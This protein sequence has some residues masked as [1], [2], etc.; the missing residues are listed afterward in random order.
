MRL[1][2]L[3]LLVVL[4]LKAVAPIVFSPTIR[5]VVSSSFS[6]VTRYVDTAS[7]AGGDGTTALTSGSTRAFASLR[8]A[9]T[10][11]PATLSTP[12]RI[13]CV[14]TAADTLNCD[15]PYWDFE[16]SAANYLEVI[17]NNNTG[18][19]ST[20]HYR[21]EIANED[22]IY[23]SQPG[24]LRFYNLQVKVAV[25]TSA[26]T[27][28]NCMRVSTMNN[29]NHPVDHRIVNCIIRATNS[30]TDMADGISMSDSGGTGTCSIINTLIYDCKYG[31]VNGDGSTFIRDNLTVY[32][33]TAKDNT[34]NFGDNI[35]YIN[36]IAADGAVLNF[37]S[38]ITT[39]SKYNAST[40][41]S[42]VPNALVF[43]ARGSLSS[44]TDATSYS[45]SGSYDPTDN[46]L[47]LACVVNSKASSPDIPTFS[48]NGLT[49]VQVSTRVFGGSST[50]RQTVFRA[51]GAS[52]TSTA[53]TA[54]FAGATQTGCI[55]KVIEYANA[56]T[57]GSNGSGAIVQASTN[58]AT[59][60]NPTLTLSALNTGK[61]NAVIGFAAHLAGGTTYGSAEASWTEST[62]ELAYSTPTSGMVTVHRLITTDNSITITG[63]STDWC[64]T[65][66]EVCPLGNPRINQTFTFVNA[67]SDD[68]HLDGAD[69]GAKDF[70]LSD[71]ASGMF[72]DD[73]DAQARG[74]TWSIG[75]DEP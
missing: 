48:G 75:I 15:Q 20:S 17:G 66:I 30:G 21:L 45:T 65:G 34:Y 57:S 37:I 56:E 52:P 13:Y 54:D 36:C 49:W 59:S 60:T 67:A 24:H 19:W 44:T 55:I 33:C 74:S 39:G 58:A 27:S 41:D 61:A 25:T 9:L 23:N 6:G 64:V 26:G 42:A 35:K 16:T 73:I 47:V 69:A 3:F 71:P 1:L 51:M 53:G 63:A 62:P 2:C 50:H 40:D 11:L 29:L 38:P 4:P 31:I 18:K 10:S 72:S 12:Y 8:E 43:T 28:Y 32:N 46:S 22:G 7:S 14:G 5:T 70:G 68:F